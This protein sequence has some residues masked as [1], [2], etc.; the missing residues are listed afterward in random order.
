MP[1]ETIQNEMPTKSSGSKN[2]LSAF[3]VSVNPTKTVK[4]NVKI[5]NII[6]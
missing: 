1:I 5:F 3:A 6:F 2:I 4:K